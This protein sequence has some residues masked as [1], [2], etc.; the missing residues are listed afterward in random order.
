MTQHDSD[1]LSRQARVSLCLPA[2]CAGDAIAIGKTETAQTDRKQ[3]TEQSPYA[4]GLRPRAHEPR[5]PRA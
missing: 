4:G 3:T 1:P 2:E 5:L